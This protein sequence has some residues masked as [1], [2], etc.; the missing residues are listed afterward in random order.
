MFFY[1]YLFGPSD[2]NETELKNEID[3]LLK[4][5]YE[6]SSLHKKMKVPIKIKECGEGIRSLY[7]IQKKEIWIHPEG[8]DAYS[9]REALLHEIIHAYDHQVNKIPLSTIDGLARSEIHAMKLCE[10]RDA[11]FV[12]RCTR[13]KA[14]EAVTLSIKDRKK[15][16]NIVESIF[17]D[18]YYDDFLSNPF[19]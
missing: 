18:V 4:D 13:N 11:W 7:H 14:I 5:D 19:D 12:K 16:E 9:L 6:I 2:F 15:A 17:D 10:C 1:N 8:Y 3:R